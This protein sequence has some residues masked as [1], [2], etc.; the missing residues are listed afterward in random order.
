MRGGNIDVGH[1]L[2]RLINAAPQNIAK[3]ELAHFTLA[4]P[5]ETI[6]YKLILLP[7][8]GSEIA[9]AAALDGVALARS[10]GAEAI[11]V[12]VT[13][14]YQLMFMFPGDIPVAYPS[15]AEYEADVKRI[16]E[17]HLQ[18]IAEAARAAGVAWK[19]LTVSANLADQAIV[20]TAKKQKC[21]LIV[22]GSHGRGGLGRLLLGSVTNKVLV[23]C[24]VPVL[25]HRPGAKRKPAA[26]KP[27]TPRKRA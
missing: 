20:A 7:I 5:K 18:V 6:M 4:T 24:H 10:V 19:Q 11:G 9:R 15:K 23:S 16:A 3:I 13:D 17:K 21:D 1:A 26:K 2:L 12:C 27:A 8:D 25:V 22:M 14:P